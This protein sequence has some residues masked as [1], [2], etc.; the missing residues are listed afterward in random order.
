VEEE[1]KALREQITELKIK[2]KAVI[3][4]HNYQKEEIQDI[5]DFVGDSF[6]LSRLAASSEGDVIVFCGVYFMAEVAAILAPEKVVLLPDL[7]AGCPLA[8]TITPEELREKKR[9]YPSAAVVAYIN[10][11]AAVKAISDICVTSSNAVAVVNSLEEEEVLF[12]PDMNLG[13]FVAGQ[14]E[15]RLILWEGC[16]PIHHCVTVADVAAWRAAYPDAAVVVHP[17]CRPEVVEAA[18]HAF[19]TGGMIKFARETEYQKIVVGTENGLIHRLQKENP[20]K[21]FYPLAAGLI[22]PNMKKITLEKVYMALATLEPRIVVP[23]ALR[24]PARRPLDRM[25]AAV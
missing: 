11:S 24:E 5:A 4:A 7:T 2:R 10:S 25:L 20:S 13:S 15:K 3:L 17:E 22:C 21:E 16:C 18:D 23:E 19:S 1:K 9:S 12:V 14:T 8:D 6:E